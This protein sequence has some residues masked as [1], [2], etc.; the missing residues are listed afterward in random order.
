MKNKYMN[1][2]SIEEKIRNIRKTAAGRSVVSKSLVE[3]Y[4]I[5][6]NYLKCLIRNGQQ[7]MGGQTFG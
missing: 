4:P 2:R 1:S 6:G 3:G 5:I 7:V